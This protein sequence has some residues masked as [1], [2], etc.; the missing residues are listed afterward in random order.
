V[1]DTIHVLGEGGVV[2]EMALPLHE[3]IQGRLDAGELR[4]VNADGTP[5]V[6]VAEK[7]KRPATRA[8]QQ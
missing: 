3:A 2:F 1:P 5:Y 6:E 4:R 7:V 8:R